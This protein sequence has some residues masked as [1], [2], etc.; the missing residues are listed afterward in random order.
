MQQRTRRRRV[1]ASPQQQPQS[2]Q[3]QGAVARQMPLPSPYNRRSALL[4]P[5]GLAP[6]HLSPLKTPPAA[7]EHVFASTQ[8]FCLLSEP[9]RTCLHSTLA[10]VGTHFKFSA[11]IWWACVLV[12]S[13][14]CAN[15]SC[16]L[17]MATPVP[18]ASQ[19][20]VHFFTP[21]PLS[22]ST[23]FSLS[24]VSRKAILLPQYLP[25][26]ME[27]RRTSQVAGATTLA[28]RTT[29]PKTVEVWTCCFP[30]KACTKASSRVML[31]S[32][33]PNQ[34]LVARSALRRLTSTTKAS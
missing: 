12:V 16:S 20:H 23:F 33:F 22:I 6:N 29:S 11:S 3:Q 15:H 28:M 31:S 24:S 34:R 5:Q 27:V 4:S 18:S 7:G 9:P 17:Q 32:K 25:W 30:Y 14:L 10:G 2:Q 19:M 13:A 21:S 8:S 26:R 1:A